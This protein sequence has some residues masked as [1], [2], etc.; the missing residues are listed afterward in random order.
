MASYPE[1][2]PQNGAQRYHGGVVE[3]RLAKCAPGMLLKAGRIDIQHLRA[4]T[5][6]IN[7]GIKV[8]IVPATLIEPAQGRTHG[9]TEIL[10]TARRHEK[11]SDGGKHARQ[12]FAFRSHRARQP[13]ILLGKG[14]FE[15]ENPP[16]RY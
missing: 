16:E 3:D 2:A 6:P 15:P 11:L 10:N 5:D 4:T 7:D 8:D 14:N 9:R 1:D 12:Y 13:E